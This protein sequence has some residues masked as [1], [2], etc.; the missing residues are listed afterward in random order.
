MNKR[1]ITEFEVGERLDKALAAALPQYSRSSLEKLIEDGFAKVNAQSVKASYKLKQ[2]DKIT[3]DLSPFNM[4]KAKLKIDILFEN[5]DIVV[6]NKPIGVLTHSKGV[7]NP[8][9]TVATWLKKHLTSSDSISKL[10]ARK[11]GKDFIINERESVVHRLDRATSGVM[12]LAKN[13]VTQ[14]YLQKQ[15]AKRNVKKAYNAI[16]SGQLPEKEGLI[17]LPIERNP[18]NP[19][20]F[21]VGAGGKA[22]ETYFKVIKTKDGRSLVELKPK[23]GRTHQLRVHLNYFGCPIIGDIVYGGQ[24]NE[25][26][27]L[28]ALSLEV[29]LPSGSRQTFTAKLPAEFKL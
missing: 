10:R 14:N 1:K 20:T 7:F 4:P 28:H 25:R 5:A 18:K 21:R 6:I 23:T 11:H 24:P 9:L 12:I 3:V 22:A 15:F 19:A 29:T 16:I 8:E 2:N 17:D 13:R 26:L 27:L